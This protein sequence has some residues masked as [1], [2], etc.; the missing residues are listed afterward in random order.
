MTTSGNLLPQASNDLDPELMKGLDSLGMD[1]RPPIAKSVSA[2]PESSIVLDDDCEVPLRDPRDSLEN[3]SSSRDL[4]A[5]MH[6]LTPIDT[7]YRRPRLS[8]GVGPMQ[9]TINNFNIAS[10]YP[11]PMVSTVACHSK[12]FSN[13][14]VATPMMKPVGWGS[15]PLEGRD[16]GISEGCDERVSQALLRMLELASHEAGTYFER[17]GRWP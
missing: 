16:W 12:N 7:H 4:M 3:H 17:Q 10:P 15:C 14:F 8:T 1:D 9:G 6:G 5:H 2:V 11:Q 13:D